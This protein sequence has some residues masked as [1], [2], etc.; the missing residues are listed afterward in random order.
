MFNTILLPTDGS[1]LSEK[2]TVTAI[3]FAQLN[4]AKIIGISVVQPFPFSPM[5][6]GGAVFDAGQYEREM[7]ETAQ[8][9]LD[10]VGVA[11]RE[12]Q[13]PFEGVVSLSASPYEEIVATAEKYQ[14]DIIMM[15]SHGRKGLNKLFLG[16][17][18]QK[19]LAHTTL[20]V[21]VLR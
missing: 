20:P 5:S 18:T 13:V 6:D 15:A 8:R 16:S 9:N 21:M 1:A 17:E 11:A 4:N 19:V 3:R 2:A 7:H 12:A 14:C 10:K